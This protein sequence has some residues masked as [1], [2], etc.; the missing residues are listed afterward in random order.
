MAVFLHDVALART[1]PRQPPF[2]DGHI[3]LPD[4]PFTKLR[5]QAIRG[6]GRSRQYH[7]PGRGPI[8]SM[9][10]TNE[11]V[12]GLVE[13]ML[14]KVPRLTQEIHVTRYVTLHQHPAPLRYHEQ[15]VVKKQYTRIARPAG[16]RDRIG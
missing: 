12:S 2:D 14:E 7:D 4:G 6:L 5:R 10:K 13:S 3:D 1:L 9:N 8:D 15:V 16:K 11:H